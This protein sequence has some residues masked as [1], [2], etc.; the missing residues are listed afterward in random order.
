M[1][2]FASALEDPSRFFRPAKGATS[3]CVRF[4]ST[5]LYDKFRDLRGQIVANEWIYGL[6][7]FG[8]QW[9]Q[10]ISGITSGSIVGTNR[11]ITSSSGPP[12]KKSRVVANIG[13]DEF[14]TFPEDNDDEEDEEGAAGMHYSAEMRSRFAFALSDMERAGLLRCKRVNRSEL[15]TITREMHTWL[16]GGASE[17]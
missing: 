1:H 17:A 15:V 9:R 13:L 10:D 6:S 11:Q 12:S 8:E 16:G 7:V 14:E 4:D 2:R 5:D 3:S